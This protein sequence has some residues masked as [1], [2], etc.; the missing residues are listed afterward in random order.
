MQCFSKVSI[1]ISMS[2]NLSG[3]N[4]DCNMFPFFLF[5]PK[6][7][8]VLALID[9]RKRIIYWNVWMGDWLAFTCLLMPLETVTIL[10]SWDDGVYASLVPEKPVWPSAVSGEHHRF[11]IGMVTY[12]PQTYWWMYGMTLKML[13]NVCVLAGLLSLEDIF[14]TP[15]LL[16]PFLG[17]I[18]MRKRMSHIFH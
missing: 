17:V 3:K 15:M 6:L 8:T 10:I 2:S 11:P 1:D 13:I 12:Q 9:L 14:L 4:F 5:L 7:T 18:L 16:P